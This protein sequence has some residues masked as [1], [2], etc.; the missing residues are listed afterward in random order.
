MAGDVPGSR[1]RTL[2][3]RSGALR[4]QGRLEAPRPGARG[5][6]GGTRGARRLPREAFDQAGVEAV[7]ARPRDPEHGPDDAGGHG[8]RRQGHRDVREGR[9]PEPGR[10]LDPLG[11][12]RLPL[13]ASRAGRARTA[14]GDE[15]AGRERRRRVPGGPRAPRRPPRRDPGGRRPRR[16]GGRHR[17][18]PFVLPGRPV[19]AV[20]RGARRRARGRGQTRTSR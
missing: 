6:R 7:G 16:A 8:H 1:D 4:A 13:P 17:P 11:G 12:R 10:P 5:R 15:R 20:L 9:P 19:R 14:E 3:P 18:Q 2:A